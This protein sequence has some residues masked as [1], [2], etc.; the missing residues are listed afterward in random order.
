MKTRWNR[1]AVFAPLLLSGAAA[2]GSLPEPA[3]GADAYRYLLQYVE[4]APYRTGTPGAAAVAAWIGSQ[5]GGMG[6]Q[7]TTEDFP[8]QRYVVDSASVQA[9]GFAPTVFALYYSGTTG[10]A[11]VDGPIADIGLGTP[12]EAKRAAG[13][14]AYALIPYPLNLADPTFN[15]VM[16]NA[17]AAGARA[18]V[19]SFTSAPENEVQVPDVDAHT[20]LCGLPVLIVGKEDGRRLASMAGAMT[21]FVL[22]AHLEDASY[23]NVMATLPGSSSDI[24]MVGT[25]SNDWFAGAGERGGGV[26]GLLTLARYFAQRGPYGPT[27]QFVAL[28]GH[29]VGMLG[30]QGY[31][32]RHPDQVPHIGAYIHLGASVATKLYEELDGKAYDL[33]QPNPIIYYLSEN[34]LLDTIWLTSMLGNGALVAAPLLAAT[35]HQGEEVYM[36]KAKVPIA[37]ISAP[38]YW[39][40][41]PGDLPYDTSAALLDPVVKGYRDTIQKTLGYSAARLKAA[42][43]VA[44]LLARPKSAAVSCAVAPA[45]H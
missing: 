8:F 15:A 13:G 33:H 19:V 44:D 31:L 5:L 34:P 18:L 7:V 29:E 45:Q 42:N 25:P 39:F 12:L 28:G 41:S 2:A 26:G 43:T 36:Y 22:A 3:T 17:A 27:L 6:Y 11:G 30:L 35:E 37:A 24:V 1:W 38:T 9:G 20:G 32:A 23:T 16:K 40:H 10:S 21:H 4:Q 14:I